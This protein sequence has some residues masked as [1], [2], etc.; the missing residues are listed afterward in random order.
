MEQYKMKS[1]LQLK[2]NL[3]DEE[4]CL[5]EKIINQAYDNRHGRIQRS[6]G[7]NRYEFIFEGY[8]NESKTKTDRPVLESGTIDLY[9]ELEKKELLNSIEQWKWIEDEPMECC[10]VIEICSTPVIH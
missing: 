9:Y 1:V 7:T 2:T 5:C 4:L 8:E 3:S 6:C 10:D